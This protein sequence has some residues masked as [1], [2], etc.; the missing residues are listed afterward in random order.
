MNIK[1]VCFLYWNKEASISVQLL[2]YLQSTARHYT[3][4]QEAWSVQNGNEIKQYFQAIWPKTQEL[5]N[6]I[7]RQLIFL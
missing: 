7:K 5:L 6:S 3:V 2:V 1:P 4:L